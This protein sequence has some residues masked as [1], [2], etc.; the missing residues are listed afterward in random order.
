[1]RFS[2]APAPHLTP[3]NSVALV[4]RQVLFALVPA[5]IAYVWFFG[6][7][8]LVNMLIAITVALLCEAAVLHLRGRPIKK[9]I[10]DYSAVLTAVLL[11]FAIPPLTPWWVTAI[12]VMFAIVFAKQLFG[13]LG[14]NPFN[15]AMAGYVVL[16]ISFPVQMT[17]WIPPAVTG[18]PT[19]DFSIWQT[20]SIILTGSLPADTSWD[21]ITMA[22]PL[23]QVKTGLA[24]MQTVGE[25]RQNPLF[26]DF[27]GRGWEWLANC[28]A[29]GG[30][31]L[32]YKG[33]IRWHI[34]VSM[35]GSIL[36]LS[37]IFYLFDAGSHPSPAFHLFG[38][39]TMIGAFFI[40]T[41]PV[42]A[43]TTEKGRLI[44]GAGIGVL[45]YV[46]RSWGGYPDGVA[47]AVLIMNMAVPLI[48][49][50]T[51][52]RVYGHER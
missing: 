42:S 6:P 52:P 31:W 34:P 12:G 47:F 33:I 25:I 15:P 35:I 29:L 14:Y 13:G 1:M 10:G 49:K 2:Q 9:Y 36:V 45:T 46:I 7:G 21:A 27:G 19:P 28:F 8:L 39:A 43:A 48:D 22:T 38:G 40:A 30:F 3:P 16:L 32:L 11:A 51:V 5:A 50:V 23:D 44:Y 20:I 18:L 26:G 24:L 41:D 4:M 17:A 37:T